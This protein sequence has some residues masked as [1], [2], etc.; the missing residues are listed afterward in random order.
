VD[1]LFMG[2]IPMPSARALTVHEIERLEDA[3]ADAAGRARQAGFDAVL[4][5]GGAG[6]LIG[7]FMSP[8]VNRRTDEYGGDL[9]G[10]MRFPLRIVQK[11]KEK[12]G[13]ELA[14][15][16]DLPTDELIEGGIR[17]EESKL[18]ARMLEEAGVD[19]FRIHVALY[20]TYQHVV[21]PAAVPRG[22]HAGRA[23]AIKESVTRAKVMLGHRINDPVLAEDLLQ[24][25]AADIILMGRPLIAD[26]ELCRKVEEGRLADIRKC[27]ACNIGCVGNIVSGIPATCTVNPAVGR[28]RELEIVPAKEPKKVLVVGGGVGGMEAAR[29][30]A[31]RGHRVA[32]YEKEDHLGGWAAVGCIP[33]HK[34]EIRE[35]IGYFETQMTRLRV[36]VRL[37]KRVTAEDIVDE[38]PDAVILATGS[39]ELVPDIPGAAAANVVTAA[40]VLTGKVETGTKVVILGGGQTGLETAEFLAERGKRVTVLEMLSEVG[41]D[42]ELISKIF[43]MPRLAEAG[44]VI[45]TDCRVEEI[46]A[47][48]VKCTTETIAAD[49]V[50]IAAGLRASRISSDALVGRIQEVH[51]IGDCVKPRRLLDAIHEGAKVARSIQ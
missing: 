18:M 4:I 2:V 43:M 5:D 42:M 46:Q 34:Q 38:K 21:P 28:E 29:V 45:R 13:S 7:Q 14:L 25:E 37:G 48:G 23:R 17:L 11:T 22:V 30:A 26:P 36:D 35:L 40:A 1:T 15:L 8:F 16:F 24:Q 39:Q 51:E 20:E 9:K 3:F 33:P 31:L 49:T 10:R 27:I 12:I 41:R 50:V 32:L 19:G 44:I 6:Y 47:Q